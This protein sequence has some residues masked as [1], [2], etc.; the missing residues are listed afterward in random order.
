MPV[1]VI[2]ALFMLIG[3]YTNRE[4]G[5]IW[6]FVYPTNY[7]FVASI[8]LLYI[9]YYAVIRIA[10]LK[11]RI[12][13]VMSCIGIIALPVY[14]LGYDRSYYH[15]DTVREPFIRF[16]FMESMPLGA[17]F[18]QKDQL[19]RNRLSLWQVLAAGGVFILY[20][21]SKIVFSRI[22]ELASVQ[23]INQGI[24]FVLLY[25]IFRL[26][27]GLDGIMEKSPGFVKRIVSFLAKITLEIYVVQYVLID[28]VRS[29]ELV[30]PINWICVTGLIILAAV[31]LHMVCA[32]FRRVITAVATKVRSIEG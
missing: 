17:Y 11:N 14:L 28:F 24:L 5:L 4:H 8:V 18:R 21:A 22:P 20:F 2:T 23:I 7:H 32:V 30:F 29:L 25:L 9:P 19:F 26:F 10:W 12:P 13:L 16:L 31:A 1:I 3:A 6:W 27:A 15:I